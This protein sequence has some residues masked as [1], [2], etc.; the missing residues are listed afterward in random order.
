MTEHGDIGVGIEPPG[1]LRIVHFP[2]T[3]SSHRDGFIR[4]RMW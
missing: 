4:Y 2:H 1:R 3:V